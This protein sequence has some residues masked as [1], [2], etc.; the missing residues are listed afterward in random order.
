MRQWRRWPT[1][2]GIGRGSGRGS[3]HAFTPCIYTEPVGTYVL[4]VCKTAPCS[5]MGADEIID[6]I[7]QKLGYRAGR[8]DAGRHVHAV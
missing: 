1:C 8:N 3:S 4:E 6:Y 7:S 5:Y 2:L